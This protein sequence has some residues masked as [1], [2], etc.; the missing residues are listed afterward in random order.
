MRVR[1]LSEFIIAIVV[2]IVILDRA[3]ATRDTKNGKKELVLGFNF[4]CNWL[5]KACI[6]LLFFR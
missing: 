3:A 4:L 6:N 5:Q 2:C 1:Y